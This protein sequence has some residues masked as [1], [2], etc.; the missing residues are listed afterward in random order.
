MTSIR[1]QILASQD[2]QREEVIISE[3]GGV[4][5]YLTGLSSAERD[6]LESSVLKQNGKAQSVNLANYR[7]KLCVFGI[8]D[9]KGQRVFDQPG[10]IDRLGQKAAV[11]T[12][13]LANRIQILSGITK[14][15]VEEI[16]KNSPSA[17]LDGFFSA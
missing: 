8:R 17:E 11:V 14:E 4:T 9:E 16:T 12:E 2:I 7:A 1:D 13:R 6:A 15:D 3:W 10:D 5:V